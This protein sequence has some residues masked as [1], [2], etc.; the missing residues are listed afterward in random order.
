VTTESEGDERGEGHERSLTLE[1][2]R[3]LEAAWRE[4]GF[5]VPHQTTYPWQWLW[6]SCFHSV[7]W[8]ALGDER[9]VIELSSAL[10]AIDDDG[11]VPHIRYA[12]GPFPHVAL[13]GR[14]DTSSITQPPMYG[15]AVAELARRGMDVPGRVVERA[16]SALR[17]L[18][19]TRRRSPAGLVL[20]C[21]PWESGCDDSPRWDD[22]GCGTD[23]WFDRKG[24]LVT[25]IERTSGG[26][27]IANPAFAVGGVGFSALVA[28]NAL[29]L[30]AVTG[31]EALA[32]AATEL[33]E[34]VDARWDGRLCTWVDDGPSS[35]ASGRARTLDAL[36]PLL[37]RDN[38]EAR[39]AVVDGAAFGG[40]CGPA[41]VHRAEPAYAPERYWRGGAWPPLSYLLWVASTRSGDVRVADALAEAICAG[42]RISGFA[43]WW[44]PDSGEGFGAVPQSWATLAA[45]VV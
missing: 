9:A 33:A 15:H 25:T 7:V 39:A 21:H 29:E 40:S 31:D 42:A 45:L 11:F 44:D 35:I 23:S 2:R 34:A 24:E 22:W 32:S 19:G 36:L 37:L 1:A 13:W 16:T 27:P 14:P 28:W 30:T 26:A 10:A 38:D 5:C 3:I 12:N 8:A 41:G 6:D 20:L 43:E 4:P 18:L 17:F